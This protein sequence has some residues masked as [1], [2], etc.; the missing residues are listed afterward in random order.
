MVADRNPAKQGRL[1]P[2][3]RIP[4]VTPE[5]L[6]AFRPDEVLILPWNIAP[7]V[8][9]ELRAIRAWGGRLLVAVPTLTEIPIPA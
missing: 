4:V 9:G 3:S 1:L 5:E 2:G 8:A 7:E 6:L